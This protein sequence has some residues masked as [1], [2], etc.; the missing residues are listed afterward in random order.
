MSLTLYEL[1]GI[2]MIK[3]TARFPAKSENQAVFYPLSF[4]NATSAA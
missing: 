1:E 3:K 4:E 2:F